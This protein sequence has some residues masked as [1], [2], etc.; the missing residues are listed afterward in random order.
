MS[1]T[2]NPPSTV[3]GAWRT[4]CRITEFFVERIPDTLWDAPVPL[5]PRRTVRTI[6]GHLHNARARWTRTLGEPHGI[7]THAL[8]N[9]NRVRRAELLRAL[10]RS[11]KS[12]EA[13]LQLGLD[14]DDR[15]PPTPSYT[16]RNL[17]LD[18]GHV[19]TYFAGH[20]AHHRGQIVMIARQLGQRLPASAVDGVWMW[21]Q[22]QREWMGDSR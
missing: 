17:P 22:R 8:V 10:A 1:P 16:W 2:S 13:I 12:I 20:E 19:L 14:S 4:N 5:I 18:V 3:I 9:L 21:T 11:A 6:L 7:R 15:V